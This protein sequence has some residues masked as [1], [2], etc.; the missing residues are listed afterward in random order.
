MK[1]K[2]IHS[3]HSV[4]PVPL[5]LI[6]LYTNIA[7]STL[8]MVSLRR[9][10]M[11]TIVAVVMVVVCA[12]PASA[13][14]DTFRT[15]ISQYRVFFGKIFLPGHGE[16]L[17]LRRFE[18]HN[19]KYLITVDPATMETSVIPETGMRVEPL[20]GP[21]F[22]RI[23]AHTP[24]GIAMVRE[25]NSWRPMQNA[26]VTSLPSRTSGIHLTIDLCPSR[27]PLTRE[28]FTKII[29]VFSDEE[30][31]VPVSIAVTGVWMKEHPDDL[32]WLLNL[33]RSGALRIRWINHT[34]HHRYDPNLPVKENF[35]LKKHTDIDAEVLGNEQAMLAHG[36][37]PSL[38]FRFP[39]LV[40]DSAVFERITGYGLLPIGSDAWLAKG[41][42]PKEGSVV[43]IHGNGNEPIGVKDFMNLLSEKGT[44]I[45]K[46][47]WVLLDVEQSLIDN[48]K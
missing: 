19:K 12:V 9:T 46:K 44:A 16:R 41:E 18:S 33:D 5:L 39:G 27:R 8:T 28:V 36:I 20:T 35:L 30:R 32:A 25:Q 40:S 17:S 7:D 14:T 21:Q 1:R 38:F 37:V 29:S 13:K 42:K 31:P 10:S 22:F 15:G 24:Y 6:Q 4:P 43:L 11:K 45:R 48:N 34:L 2:A 47:R 26:G 23:V 3:N